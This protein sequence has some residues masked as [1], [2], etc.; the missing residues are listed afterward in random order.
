MLYSKWNSEC[1]VKCNSP[2]VGTILKAGVIFKNF[3]TNTNSHNAACL[4]DLQYATKTKTMTN[5][6][7]IAVTITHNR[8]LF[9]TLG[10]ILKYIVK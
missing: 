5:M 1:G 4:H 10:V 2:N 8:I 3:K 6:V 9:Y 7:S